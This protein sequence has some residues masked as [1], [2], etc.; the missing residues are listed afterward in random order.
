VFATAIL[1]SYVGGSTLG[2]L[3][4]LGQQNRD[5]GEVLGGAII[6]A[7]LAVIIDLVLGA[8]QSALTSGP[9][10]SIFRRAVVTVGQRFRREA[11]A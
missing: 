2:D 3:V 1:A 4:Y 5:S 10:P 9:N 8:V 11:I 7:I 6:I